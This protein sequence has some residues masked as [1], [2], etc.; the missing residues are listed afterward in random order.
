MTFIKNKE[1]FICEKCGHK[2]EGTGYTNHCP[3]CLYSKHVDVHPGDRA[4]D[5]CGLMK[6]SGVDKRGPEHILIHKCLNCGEE[7]S[8][9]TSDNDDF[10]KI[11]EV[12][13]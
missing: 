6:P 13:K 9:K 2:V 3:K 5:C 1:D 11:I 10:E 8:C 4:H 7:K 12:A